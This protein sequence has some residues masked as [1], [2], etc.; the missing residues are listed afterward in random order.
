MDA[1]LI[2][3]EFKVYLQ[4]KISTTNEM[5]A[6][7]EALVRWIHPTEGF[8]PPN[9]FIPIFE[10]NG[11]ILKLDDYMLEEIAKQQAQWIEQGQKNRSNICKYI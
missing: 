9:K 6:G 3:H 8:I 2:N 5:L 4:P 11:F 7:A 10:R 1:A